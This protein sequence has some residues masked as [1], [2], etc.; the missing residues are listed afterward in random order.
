MLYIVQMKFFALFAFFEIC[1][2]LYYLLS[3]YCFVSFRFEFG[4]EKMEFILFNL[5][6]KLRFF[7]IF[8]FFF[9]QF[10]FYSMALDTCHRSVIKNRENLFDAKNEYFVR[11]K[12]MPV[13]TLSYKGLIVVAI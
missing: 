8:F 10:V 13:A 11:K 3:D 9:F 5:R 1:S 6:M 2:H 4:N 12:V 7:G